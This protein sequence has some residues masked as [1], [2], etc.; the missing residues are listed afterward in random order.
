MTST[1]RIMVVEDEGIVA[2][3]ICDSLKT[4]G[5]DVVTYVDSGERAVEEAR[6]LS[7]DA[8]LM[9]INLKGQMDGIDAAHAIFTSVKTPI[10]FLTAH[11]DEATL[12]RAK[13][14]QPFGY[15]IKPFDSDELRTTIELSLHRAAQAARDGMTERRTVEE[16]E[17]GTPFEGDI[18]SKADLQRFLAR[19]PFFA[20]VPDAH[21]QGLAAAAEPKTLE[22]GDVLA[23]QEEELQTAFILLNG[24]L[25]ASKTAESGKELVFELLAPGDVSGMLHWLDDEVSLATFRAQVPSKIIRFPLVVVRSLFEQFPALYRSGAAELAARYR[26]LTDLAMSLAHAKVEQRIVS[27][28]LALGPRFGKGNRPDQTRIFLTRKELADLAGT[29]PET[30]IRVTKNLEREG[31]LDLSR[32]GIIKILSLSKLQ[33]SVASK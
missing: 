27:T 31:M 30:A 28:L 24:R 3:D 10:I 15:I 14:T 23:Y 26:R 5:Y 33:E 20:D 25:A 6:R 2:L 1:A 11:A 17:E 16:L 9:D 4:L 7:P 18:N 12:Q 19:L 21:L 13:L 29:T 8:I 32:A 22:G